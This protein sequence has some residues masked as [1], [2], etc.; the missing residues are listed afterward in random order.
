MTELV[1][2][3]DYP[4]VVASRFRQPRHAGSLPE[5]P[6]VVSGQSGSQRSGASVRL[7]LQF[8]DGAVKHAYFAAYGCP[9]FIAAAETLAAWT[10][11]RTVE[12]LSQWSWQAVEAELGVPANKRGSLLALQKALSIVVIAH[13]TTQAVAG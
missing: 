8:A 5:G 10:E 4:A 11:G 9:Y 12:Q 3:F 7:W 6:G 2:E 1:S 13:R